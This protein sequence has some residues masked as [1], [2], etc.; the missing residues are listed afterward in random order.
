MT[1]RI[2]AFGDIHMNLGG[3]ATVPGIDTA[4]LLIITGDLTNFGGRCEAAKIIAAVRAV[5]PNLLALAGN[6]DRPEVN[7]YLAAEGLSLH[8]HGVVRQHV[9]IFGAG[10]SNRTPFAT[11]NEFSEPELAAILQQGFDR[12][13]SAEHHILVSHAPP[14]GTSTDRLTDGTQVGSKSVR[15]FIEQHQP[16]LCL[17]GHI[18]EA[19]GE[20]NIGRTRIFN[21]GMIAA[22]GWVEVTVTAESLNAQLNAMA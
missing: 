22:G 18:H 15:S 16:A 10:G 2:I 17:T 11:P 3:L 20:D 8:G 14:A 6:L 1:M 19:M 4:D 13:V 21:P 9:G 5:N 7:D 12:V